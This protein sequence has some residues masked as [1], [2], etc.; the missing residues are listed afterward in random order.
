VLPF[1][2]VASTA[3]Q[4][5]LEKGTEMAQ[6]ISNDWGG[7]AAFAPGGERDVSRFDPSRADAA[8]AEMLAERQVHQRNHH[9]V[10]RAIGWVL[11][12]NLLAFWL[13]TCIIA[14]A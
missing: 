10:W 6:L 8:E 12:A 11:L 4:R 13:M 2:R 9:Y 14:F 5:E 3:R 1:F 7:N